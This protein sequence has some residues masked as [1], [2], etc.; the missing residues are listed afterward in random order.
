MDEK[1][2]HERLAADAMKISD[3][4]HMA[5]P[6]FHMWGNCAGCGERMLMREDCG[7]YCRA[8]WRR[9]AAALDRT[10]GEL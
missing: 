1:E 6:R 3:S 4:E 8:C 7:S 2:I 5:D 9:I 10:K